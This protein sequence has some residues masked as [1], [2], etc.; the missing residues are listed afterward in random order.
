MNNQQTKGGNML[1]FGN[2]P[3][4]GKLMSG[5]TAVIIC[6]LV[7]LVVI[8]DKLDSQETLQS[9]VVDLRMPTNVAGHDLVNGINYSLAALRGYMILDKPAFKQQRQEAWQEINHNLALLTKKSSNWTNEEN[10]KQLTA[11]KKLM[12]EFEQAQQTVEDIANTP[13]EQPGM[14]ILQE[15][16]AP[17]ATVI[18]Q[19]ITGLINAEKN[20]SA[21]AE[22]KV[23][24][25]NLA[26]SRGS[27][28][29]SL[30][31]IRAFLL[32]GDK[33]WSNDFDKYWRNNQNALRKLLDS[34]HLLSAGQRSFFDNYYENIQKFAPLPNRMFTIR[35]SDQWNKANFLLATEAAPRA[36]KLLEMLRSMVSSQN[37][38]VDKDV[39]QLRQNSSALKSVSIMTTLIAIVI[40]I[41]IGLYITR[42]I[43]RPLNEAIGFAE[44]IADGKLDNHISCQNTDETGQLIET[45]GK[46]QTQ[47]ADRE[48]K[49]LDYVAQIKAIG[50]SLAV[51]EFDMQGNILDANDN[52]LG[53]MGYSLDEIQGK[54]HSMFI[55]TS[56]KD[57]NEYR[58][59]WAKLNR[60]EYQ[61]TEYRRF[62]KGGKE[63]WIQASYNPILG[64][65][66]E[67]VKVVKFATDITATKL[68]NANY[69]GQIE[70]I[71]KAQAVIEFNMD[72]SIITANDNFQ[73][74][75]GYSLDEIQDKHHSMFVEPEERNS[76][77]YQEFWSALNRGEY[78]TGDYK[79]LGKGNKE[80]WIQAS[81]N[82]IMDVDGRPYKV[83]KFATEITAQ[84]RQAVENQKIA[85]LSSALKL[86]NANV[87]L[88]DN[89]L[90]IV[91]MNN[92][93]LSML[94]GNES[95]LRKDLPDFN[96]DELIGTCVDIFHKQPSHQRGL[97]ESLDKT[98]NSRISVA[99]LTFTLT[100]SPWSNQDGERLGT[101]VEWN[102]IT[103]E[104]AAQIEERRIADENSR[105]KQALDNV[106]T[107]TMIANAKNEII[108]MNSAVQEMMSN[109][110]K[111]IQQALPHFD[112][113][114]LMGASMDIFHKNPAHQKGLID[115]LESAYKTEIKVGE[116][117]FGLIANPITS[118][119]G[120][121][122][123]TVVEWNDRTDEVAIEK[124]I[125]DL[126]GAAGQGDLSNRIG[127]DGKS[128]FF[129][130]LAGGLNQL[131]GIAEGVIDETAT[132][133]DAMAHGDLTKRIESDYEGAFNKLK[134]DA[135]STAEKLTEVISRINNSSSAVA[136]GADEIAQGNTDLSQRTEEQ[137]SSLEETA[138]S[139]EQMTS[140]VRQNADNAKVANDLAAD[141]TTKAQKGGDVVKRAVNSMSEIND[142]SKKIADI[143]GVIDEIAFQTNLLALNAAVEAAR[144]GEQGRGFA[145]VAGEVRNLAQR[146][147]AAAK[148]IKDLIRDSVSKVQDGSQLVN[149]SGA[150]L[151]EIVEAISRVTTMIGE[152]SIASSEQ[153]EGI[154]QVNK[155]VTQM[156]E[157]T[158]QNAALVEQASAA[159][160]A[161]ADQARGMRQI[162]GFFTTG[163]SAPATGGQSPM[164]M[165]PPNE[166]SRAAD[167]AP[168]TV[169]ATNVAT[170]MDFADDDEEWEEF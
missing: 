66:G 24:L 138:S 38:L 70:A 157:M 156:D 1:N 104:L 120:E 151:S 22:R 155:A 41:V 169:P 51:I 129:L 126:I 57:S 94:Q 148:E 88:A 113:S 7:L 2:W 107:N 78:Q 150:T 29:L 12:Q 116:R 136:S 142:S 14:Q 72:G 91:Y 117:T 46:M 26:D 122:I 118:G 108:Y 145:V 95:Q 30:A 11:I 47:L 134:T 100:L 49:N 84:K 20:Q 85:E 42:K 147:A 121:R 90:N 45:I 58:E 56:L 153:S 158:Q 93:M 133:L 141:A 106:A 119:A 89:D 128:G 28:A 152:I 79:R 37:T 109:A 167:P 96:T 52:F 140:T 77:E 149:E 25:A 123:G 43:T 34:R 111:D 110:E 64:L 124:E 31:S 73:A 98:S 67:P 170:N 105:I 15:E 132:M 154:E 6:I 32:S 92:G 50:K 54:H 19:N 8:I 144:A 40:A 44:S 75:V 27:F 13:Q 137:A 168:A 3:V 165:S 74:T 53:T 17:L 163:G 36:K 102:D 86:C 159:G 161:M 81:Y 135:N 127:E 130:N 146:S 87:M 103:E 21:T 125:A 76:T 82:P 10:V 60:G 69:E 143:I 71:G 4:A 80:I 9:R 55:E 35:N 162:L 33:K 39:E 114:K 23:F 160:E 59:F 166:P 63:I 61:S 115:R 101:V 164:L 16:A 83:V 62:A 131:V 18:I 99:G 68:A 97:A 112:A 5:F 65:N 48:E 139:M